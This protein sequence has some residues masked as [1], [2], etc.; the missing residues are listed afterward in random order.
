MQQ[1]HTVI[2]SSLLASIYSK[3]CK[4]RGKGAGKKKNDT[5][6]VGTDVGYQKSAFLHIRQ[7]F[8]LA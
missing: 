4:T 1:T 3:E 8:E 7:F 5:Y 6:I 2:I